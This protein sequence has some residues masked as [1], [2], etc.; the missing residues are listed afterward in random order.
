LKHWQ[1]SCIT[2]PSGSTSLSRFVFPVSTLTLRECQRLDE[3]W[4]TAQSLV[5]PFHPLCPTHSLLGAPLTLFSHSPVSRSPPEVLHSTLWFVLTSF[6]SFNPS[7]PLCLLHSLLSLE[8]RESSLPRHPLYPFILSPV[9]LLSP[10][11]FHLHLFSQSQENSTSL[12]PSLR[13]WETRGIK[14]SPAFQCNTHSF[15]P[16]FIGLSPIRKTLRI[17]GE[18]VKIQITLGQ[19]VT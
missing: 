11:S 6:E 15:I 7:P 16:S 3:Q 12:S 4:K 18:D 2:T 13:D 5:C 17:S 8:S 14:R 9:E 1:H 19:S 10:S